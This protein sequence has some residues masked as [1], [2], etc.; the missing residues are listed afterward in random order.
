MLASFKVKLD[1][2]FGTW[3]VNGPQGQTYF[4]R[5]PTPIQPNTSRDGTTTTSA[6]AGNGTP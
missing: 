4:V 3:V 5:P 1:P 2:R 6:P